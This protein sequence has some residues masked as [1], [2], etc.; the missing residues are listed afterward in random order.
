LR[1]HPLQQSFL[2][3]DA[4]FNAAQVTETIDARFPN[5]FVEGMEPMSGVEPLTY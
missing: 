5:G 2:P 3:F 1:L 4:G